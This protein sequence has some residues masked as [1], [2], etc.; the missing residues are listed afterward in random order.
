MKIKYTIVALLSLSLFSCTEGFDSDRVNPNNP[1]TVPTYGIYNQATKTLVGTNIRGS[2]GSARM[3]LPW[4]QYSAQ[5]NYTEEDRYQY[6]EGTALSIFNTYY[7][8]ANNFKDIIKLNTDPAT[9]AI[10]YERHNQQQEEHRQKYETFLQSYLRQ[11]SQ[12]RKHCILMKKYYNRLN[13][14]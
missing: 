8:Q 12:Q 3:A 5:R 1:L 13:L 7:Q 14:R 4:V 6:R 2:F 9:K 11:D 10:A